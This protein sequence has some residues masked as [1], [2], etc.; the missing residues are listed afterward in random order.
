MILTICLLE[1]I[2]HFDTE[3]PNILITYGISSAGIIQIWSDSDAML[4]P[5]HFI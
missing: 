5:L 4:P 3:L 1:D 2:T